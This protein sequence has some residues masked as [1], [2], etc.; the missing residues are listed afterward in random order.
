MIAFHNSL[1]GNN[2]GRY[3]MTEAIVAIEHLMAPILDGMQMRH[4]HAILMS[5]LVDGDHAPSEES[6]IGMDAQIDEFLSAKRLEGCSERSIS[7]YASMLK[8]FAE[9][10]GKPTS[11]ITTDDVRTYLGDYQA[12]SGETNVTVDNIR[13]IISSFFSWLEAED[14]IC[15]SPVKRIKKIRTSKPI[16]PVYSDE[17]L[18]MAWSG[19]V[20]RVF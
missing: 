9:N 18:E 11:E 15:K 5:C 20:D 4:L 6:G 12:E 8:K 14:Y 3:E 19:F 1:V 7:Y 2:E 13:R 16:K 10:V 17:T